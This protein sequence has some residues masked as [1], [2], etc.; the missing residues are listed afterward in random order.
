MSDLSD[1]FE[2]DKD[3]KLEAAN[4]EV[5]RL[6]SLINRYD[7]HDFVKRESVIIAGP[8]KVAAYRVRDPETLEWSPIHFHMTYDNIVLGM[9]SEES[10][11]LF[12]R[13]IND[14]LENKRI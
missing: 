4:K 14:T 1:T 5:A 3:L 13:F 8:L 6:K 11:K 9:L 2:N 12:A 7:T 10:A